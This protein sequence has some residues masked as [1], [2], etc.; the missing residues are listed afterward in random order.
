MKAKTATQ[1]VRFVALSAILTGRRDADKPPSV[2]FRGVISNDP[3][4]RVDCVAS[5]ASGSPMLRAW[6]NALLYLFGA[7]GRG[8]CV[9]VDRDSGGRLGS[10]GLGSGGLGGGGL[11]GG[12]LGVGGLGGGGLGGGRLCGGGLGVG[13]FGSDGLGGG[14][15]GSDGL[16]GGGLGG[17]GLGGGGFVSGGRGG[18]LG[19]EV[20][21]GGGL[22]G[23]GL[24]GGGL[25]DAFG[26]ALRTRRGEAST[27]PTS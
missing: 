12:G 25:G 1:V 9:V 23:G 13:G 22:V 3:L 10:G 19:E 6:A 16:G 24:G 4:A 27:R 2:Q 26:G 5:V 18:E 11:G 7:S 17:G 15:L 20:D 14:R 8:C 21:G